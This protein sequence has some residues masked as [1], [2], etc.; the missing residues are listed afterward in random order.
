[1]SSNAIDPEDG[2][3]TSSTDIPKPSGAIVPVRYEKFSSAAITA[4]PAWL[5]TSPKTSVLYAYMKDGKFASY[6]NTLTSSGHSVLGTPTSGAGNGGAY[7][8]NYA[9]LFTPTDVSRVGPLNGSAS[10]TNNYWTSTLGKAQLTDTTYGGFVVTYPNHAPHVHQGKLYFL[11]FINGVGKVHFIQT[12]KT[13]VEGDTDNGSTYG[14][15]T[16]PEGYYPFDLESYGADLIIVCSQNPGTNSQSI[17]QGNAAI[18]FW[19][20]FSNKAYRKIDL[21]DHLATAILTHKGIPYIW[22]GT[23]SKGYRLS[24]YV[25]GNQVDQLESFNEGS[26]P[27]AGAVDSIGNRIVWGSNGTYPG[28]WAGVIARGYNSAKLPSTAVNN[29]ARISSPVTDSSNMVVTSL[30]FIQANQ[31]NNFKPIIGWHVS[32]S[33]SANTYGLDKVSSTAT[34]NSCFRTDIIPIGRK[35]QITNVRFPLTTSVGP[36]MTVTCTIYLDDGSSSQTLTVINDT[37]YSASQRTIIEKVNILGDH[38]FFLEFAFTG[39]SSC[40]IGLPIEFEVKLLPD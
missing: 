13:T 18:F 28:N 1:M 20:T 34:F 5:F 17:Q 26:P 16:L 40:P 38:N 39:T 21:P 27:Y 32:D 36:N 22:H 30:K 35:F 4:A 2:L 8:D 12:T 10:L 29:I 19:D 7:Y 25:G 11:D 31:T 15:F 37:N 9:Y 23:I 14:A 33:L 24:R 6:A 3:G